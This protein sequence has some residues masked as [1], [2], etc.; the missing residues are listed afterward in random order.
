MVSKLGQRAP[1]EWCS[2]LSSWMSSLLAARDSRRTS[3][4]GLLI[5]LPLQRLGGPSVDLSGSTPGGQSQKHRPPRNRGEPRHGPESHA[6]WC[7]EQSLG[8][9]KFSA[10][11]SRQVWGLRSMSSWNLRYDDRSWPSA[12]HVKRLENE[13]WPHAGVGSASCGADGVGGRAPTSV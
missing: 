12:R 8:L 6:S 3:W 11:R 9:W 4:E 13:N 7:D 2:S 5:A 1:P 10:A